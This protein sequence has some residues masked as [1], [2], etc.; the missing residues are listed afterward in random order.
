MSEL[1]KF[2]LSKIQPS[3]LYISKAKLSSVKKEMVGKEFDSIEPIPIKKMGEEI[4]FTD[5]HTRAF[6]AYQLGYKEITVEWETEDLDWEMYEI[7]V[8]WCMDE[9]I[10]TIADLVDRVVP[11]KRYEIVW[12]KRCENLHAEIEQKRAKEERKQC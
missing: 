11:H 1:F 12:Y 10:F 2:S 6:L 5:G 8:Q 7:C 9:G 4:I 3:Q